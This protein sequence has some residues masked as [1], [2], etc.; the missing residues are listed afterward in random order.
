MAPNPAAHFIQK[1]SWTL[2]LLLGAGFL[3]LLAR[4]AWVCDDSYIT[5]RYLYNLFEG[6]GLVWNTPERVQAFTHPLWLLTLLPFYAL[7]GTAYWAAVSAGLLF[8][9]LALFALF[10]V[11]PDRTTFIASLLLLAGSRA[12]VDFCSSGLE[13][14]LSYLLLVL[15]A[16]LF[17]QQKHSK[18]APLLLCL[19]ASLLLLNRLDHL[20]LVAPA[21]VVALRGQPRRQTLRILAVGFA[22]LLLWEAFALVYYGF[23]LPNTFYAKAMTGLPRGT[24][25]GQGLLYLLDSLRSDFLSLPVI[26]ATTVAGWFWAGRPARALLLGLWLYLA[27]VVWVGG[28]FMSGRFLATPFLL[29][30]LVL[31]NVKVVG[32]WRLAASGL[33]LG[34]ALLHPYHPMYTGSDYYKDRTGRERELYPHGIVDEKGMSWARS[35]MWWLD[36]SSPLLAVERDMD[37]WGPQPGRIVLVE[38]QVA[39]GLQGYA[40]GPSVFV[41]DELA[42][43]DPLLARMPALE[44]FYWRI[45]HFF[46]RVPEGYLEGLEEGKNGI[47]DPALAEYYGRLRRVTTGP[48]FSGERWRE[49]IRFNLGL[50]AGLV[51]WEA[52]RKPTAAEWNRFP[53]L[54]ED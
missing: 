32:K 34:L 17:F 33:A 26:L 13:N 45:G 3:L 38:T 6:E 37:G 50:N 14:P 41:V 1:H 39:V 42:L 7:T 18:N 49:I 40:R 21:L 30:V 43:T 44:V 8:S 54:L 16:G 10:K 2:P 4:N 48:L 23:P 47:A 28:D 35:G 27:Y 36:R 52:W 15:F 51:D 11:L 5:F 12:F 9:A 53:D 20:F 31:G 19:L 25:V 22:P 46:R 29:A 24:L